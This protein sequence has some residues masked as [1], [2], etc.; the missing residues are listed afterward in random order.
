MNLSAFSENLIFF[1]LV[2]FV[3]YRSIGVLRMLVGSIAEYRQRTC[4][5]A[6]LEDT[7]PSQDIRNAL[8]AVRLKLCHQLYKKNLE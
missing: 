7:R 3:K 5:V 2:L 4:A 6:A 8:L 1:P